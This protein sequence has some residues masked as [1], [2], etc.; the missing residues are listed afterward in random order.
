MSA[1]FAIHGEVAALRPAKDQPKQPGRAQAMASF[2]SVRRSMSGFLIL[3]GVAVIEIIG[4]L[5]KDGYWGCSTV[6]AAFQ[7]SE[8][9]ADRS[10][11]AIL[12][13]IDS[14]GGTVAGTAD[15][16][17]RV[18]DANA[19]KPVLA[20]IEDLG[21]SAAYWV[22]SQA[23]R[24][25]ANRTA[26]V[27]SIG[28]YAE[29]FD[30]SKMYENAGVKVHVV[31]ST[32][33]KGALVDGSVVEDVH[34]R[35][36][37]RVIEGMNAHFLAAIAKGRGRGREWANEQATAQVWLAADAKSRG[38][39]DGIEAWDAAVKN[40]SKLTPGMPTAS[41]QRAKIAMALDADAAGD[42]LPASTRERM[43]LALELDAAQ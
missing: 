13:L 37:R 10:V 4:A 25:T 5:S 39:I 38:L 33:L 34:L 12:L 14:P 30:T 18:K 29:V 24:I 6:N 8:T 40:A 7:L 9:E 17:D 11:K 16:A 31:A 32:P 27:G 15:L 42:T 3:D 26:L 36:V 35:E 28:T 20:H 43:R 41:V 1:I 21:A 23:R 22:A 2:S 19:I